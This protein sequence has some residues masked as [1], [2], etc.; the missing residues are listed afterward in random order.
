MEPNVVFSGPNDLN[1]GTGAVTLSTSRTVT[2]TAGNLTVG[3][4]IGGPGMTLT[5]AG[6]GGLVLAAPNTYNGGTF[7]L[8]G[9]LTTSN[10]TALSSGPVTLE[11]SSG[12]AVLALTS[13]SPT[14]GLLANSGG[15]TSLIVLGNPAAPSATALTLGANNSSISFTGIIADQSGAIRQ[16]PAAWS[17]AVRAH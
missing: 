14:I 7:V 2:V 1:L 3:G 10:D 16:P 4:A 6:A 5:K 11:P 13:G 12:T 17:R 15:G 9:T 8:A